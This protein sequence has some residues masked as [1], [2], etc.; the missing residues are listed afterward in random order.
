MSRTSLQAV[1]RIMFYKFKPKSFFKILYFP[2]GDGQ[3]YHYL[4]VYKWRH[5]YLYC[6]ES[7]IA[8]MQQKTNND[9]GAELSFKR[10]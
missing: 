7:E 10:L 5:Y 9:F 8:L 3:L 6:E 2:G 4:E 1:V